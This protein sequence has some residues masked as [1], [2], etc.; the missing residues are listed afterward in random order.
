MS[1][2]FIKEIKKIFFDFF[3]NS[4]LIC[5]TEGV[6]FLILQAL[7]TILFKFNF[8]KKFILFIPTLNLTQFLGS[9]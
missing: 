5:K 9:V 8:F 2:T 1:D 6:K 4:N 7:T 3:N